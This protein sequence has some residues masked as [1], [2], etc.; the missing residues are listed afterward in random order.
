M[1]V[2][3]KRNVMEIDESRL[4]GGNMVKKMITEL[5]NQLQRNKIVAFLSKLDLLNPT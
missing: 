1:L 2:I 4:S 3:V 5:N